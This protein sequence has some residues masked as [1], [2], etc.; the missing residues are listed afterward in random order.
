MPFAYSSVYDSGVRDLLSELLDGVRA[1]AATVGFQDVE[2]RTVS[3]HGD[4]PLALI[5]ALA[6]EVLVESDGATSRLAPGDVLLLTA[7]DPEGAIGRIS[8]K[9]AR[10]ARILA[11][12]L[13]AEGGVSARL[14]RALPRRA[15]LVEHDCPYPLAAMIGDE[16]SQVGQ[17][18]IAIVDRIVDLVFA[19]A[20]R[21]WFELH[22]E[23]APLWH[24]GTGDPIID[25]ALDLLH[26]APQQHWTGQRL[27]DRLGVSRS[28]LARR[29]Q[30]AVGRGPIGYLAELRIDLAEDLLRGTDLTLNAIAARVGYAEGFALSAA[31]KR[32]RG[33]APS[34]IR[35]PTTT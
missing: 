30:A 14:L 26:E 16:L 12:S 19:T 33:H 25:R 22:P 23:R 35:H 32:A 15:V 11:G 13:T 17:G 29:F 4:A 3:I 18:S 10:P 28:A 7:S 34:G 27:A 5:T 1:R 9:A 31:Y 24:R 20:V 6:G 8:A 2:D 21:T